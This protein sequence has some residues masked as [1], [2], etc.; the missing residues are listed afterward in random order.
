MAA[1]HGWILVFSCQCLLGFVGADEGK[2]V[3]C[4]WKRILPQNSV[5]TVSGN[6]VFNP[7]HSLG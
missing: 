6:I 5:Q 3:L 7:Y 1:E 2:L 4:H